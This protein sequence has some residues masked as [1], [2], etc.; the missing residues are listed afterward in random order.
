MRHRLGEVIATTLVIAVLAITAILIVHFEPWKNNSGKRVIFLTAVSKNGV[1]TEEKVNGSNYWLKDFKQ[2]V[3]ILKKGEEVVFR[4]TS[5]DVTHSFYVPELNIGPV[6]VWPGKVYDFPFRATK[7]GSFRYF[8]TQVCGLSHYYMQGRVIILG[9]AVN[10]TATEIAKMKQDSVLKEITMKQIPIRDST[11]IVERGRELYIRKSCYTCHGADGAG[12]IVNI[13]Y[14][15]KT[16]PP[17]NT[18][19]S[20]LKIP[21]KESADT[22]VKFLKQNIDLE[23]IAANP[24]FSTYGRFLAQYSSITKKILEGAAIVQKAD[25]AGP[26]PPLFMPAW[27]HYL[28]K[29]EIKSL[30]AYMISLNNWEEK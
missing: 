1:W 30:I 28:T 17:L 8:C 12:G 19:A 21:D 4:L 15:L 9:S 26:F 7:T 14:A 2:A 23:K 13:N 24:P 11:N 27:D 16:I 10:L 25:S 20:K 18:L 29:Q 3:I 5:M 6:T 22:I